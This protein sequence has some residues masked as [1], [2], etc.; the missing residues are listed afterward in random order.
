MKA[1]VKI[2]VNGAAATLLTGAVAAGLIISSTGALQTKNN[3]V[4][5]A[6]ELDETQE[7][8]TKEQESQTEVNAELVS[9]ERYQL[10]M[11]WEHELTAKKTTEKSTESDEKR[12]ENEKRS[13]SASSASSPLASYFSKQ[14]LV[15][16]NTVGN[17]LNV[18]VQADESAEVVNTIKAEELVSVLGEDGD[19]T[20]IGVDDMEGWVKTEYLL[21]G[22][23]AAAYMQENGTLYARVTVPNMNIRLRPTTSADILD[24][25]YEYDAYEVSLLESG[26]A[27]C[28]YDGPMKGYLSADCLAVS[29]SLGETW[30]NTDIALTEEN[31]KQLGV[32]VSES[33]AENIVLASANK[34]N[35]N[36]DISTKETAAGNQEVLTVLSPDQVMA[37]A[38]QAETVSSQQEESKVQQDTVPSSSAATNENGTANS[39]VAAPSEPAQQPSSDTVQPTVP[40][41]QP[42]SETIQPTVP[43]TQPSTEAVTVTGIEAFYVGGTKS[44]GDV[45]CSNEVYVVAA[46]SDGN[47]ATITEGWSSNDIGMMLH[48]GENVITLSYGGFSSNIV[49]TV[50]AASSAAPTTPETQPV[51]P[52][53]Q[54]AAPETQ[55]AAPETQ[56][57]AP[58]TQPAAPETQPTVPET[59]PSQPTGSIRV[60]NV[61]LSSDLTQYTLNLCSQYGVDSSVI[62][63]VMYHESHFNAGATSG[64]GAQGLM[65]IIPRYSASRMAKLGVTNLYDPASNILVGI[66]LLAEYYHTYG[67]WNQALTAYRTGNAGNDSAY[68]ATILGSVGMFQTVYYE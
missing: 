31:A 59:Q 37:M 68:A 50:A 46:Y 66:D 49:L 34:V 26:W 56:P 57:A 6:R 62:F 12:T 24:V 32:A 36:A 21:T 35:V 33:S 48:A 47:Y 11:L 23:E 5:A 20:K 65:Q 54:P 13:S 15:N 53:T 45:V 7:E 38:S 58:E 61:A 39:E 1:R 43:E 2:L 4:L 10:G 18:R 16:P 28:V 64:S 55:P 27:Y 22:E 44:E 9:A 42:S 25:A 41:T 52:E 30:I 40:E 14:A 3:D 60:T 29:Y 63:S 19:W 17:Y 8:M 51:A 67:S